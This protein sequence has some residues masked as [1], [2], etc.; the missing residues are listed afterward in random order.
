M[1]KIVLTVF[2]FAMLVSIF[3]CKG[4]TA[5]GATGTTGANGPA[6]MIFQDG[7]APYGSYSGGIDTFID[8]NNSTRNFGACDNARIGFYSDV[9]RYLVKFDLS[10]VLPSNVMV[11]KAYLTINIYGGSGSPTIDAYKVTRSWTQGSGSY[12]SGASSNNDATWE[13]YTTSQ[14]WSTAGGDY[15]TLIGSVMP[16]QQCTISIDP[17]TVQGWIS[18]PSGNYGMLLKNRDETTGVSFTITDKFATFSQRPIL[19]IYYNL[20]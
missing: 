12:T 9:Y 19:T 6:V 2:A 11:V 4:S 16:G 5:T 15:S 3:S 13:D 20:P 17:A 7:V 8:Q 18:N 14:A 10:P 1:K